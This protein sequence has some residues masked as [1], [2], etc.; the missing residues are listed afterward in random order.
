M[1]FLQAT[2]HFTRITVAMKSGPSSKVKWAHI[3][4]HYATARPVQSIVQQR[5]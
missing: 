1:Y 5:P 2:V 3:S 4:F